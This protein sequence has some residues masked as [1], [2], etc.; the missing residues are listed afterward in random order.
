MNDTNTNRLLAEFPNLYADKNQPMTK[1]LM[2]FGFAV[3]DGWYKII[4]ALSQKLEKEIIEYKKNNKDEDFPRAVQVK[5]KFG[6]LCFYMSKYTDEIRELIRDAEE[7][8][9]KT[10]ETCGRPGKAR[11]TRWVRTL[12]EEHYQQRL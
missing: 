11:D 10:C 1:S 8:C 2:C 7:K 9:S 3:D 12:C 5:E 4:Y 6:G